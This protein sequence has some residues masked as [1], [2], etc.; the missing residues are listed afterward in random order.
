MSKNL[1]KYLTVTQV[2]AIQVA[3]EADLRRTWGDPHVLV[4]INKKIPRVRT[5]IYG[6]VTTH[7]GESVFEAIMS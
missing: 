3:A 7:H 5:L 6:Q 2:A 4:V 1:E